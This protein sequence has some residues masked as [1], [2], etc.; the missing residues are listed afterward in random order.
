MSRGLR[1]PPFCACAA[2]RAAAAGQQ[3]LVNAEARA[4]GNRRPE[5]VALGTAL[6]ASTWP[7]QVLKVRIDGAGSHEV[8]GLVLSGVKFH[9]P[10]DAE[11][12]TNEVVALVQRAFM[13]SG[14]EEVDVWATVPLHVGE[15]A[16]VA[17][18]NAVPT[19]RVVYGATIRRQESATFAERLR[20]GTGVFWDAGWKESLT[21]R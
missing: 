5:A 20:S 3:A 1:S 16:V 14:V 15:H 8:A 13:R 2:L 18:D 11:G 21:A 10:V 7:A 12:F 19:T 9:Q 17:G 6:L 4:A